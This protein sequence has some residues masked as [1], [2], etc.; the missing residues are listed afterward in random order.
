MHVD[1]CRTHLVTQDKAATC[2]RRR[3]GHP[4][5]SS[6]TAVIRNALPAPAL[7]ALLDHACKTVL[8]KERR[9]CD[10]SRMHVNTQRT[11]R[12][13]SVFA[14]IIGSMHLCTCLVW[15][16]KVLANDLASVELFLE[17]HSQDPLVPIQL[18]TL[19]GKVEA[20]VLC[21]VVALVA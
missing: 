4:Q 1:T 21:Q 17:R 2:L 6:A 8:I 7:A 15:L 9:Q 3:G 5:R 11:Q 19:S 20:Y 14:S 18:S 12:I 10:H 13:V 16:V